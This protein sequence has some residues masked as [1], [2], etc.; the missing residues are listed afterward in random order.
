MSSQG[1][2]APSDPTWILGALRQHER[3]LLRYSASLVGEARARDVVQDAFLRLCAQPSEAVE[4]HVAAWLFT[5]CRNRALEL[6]RAERRFAP[7]EDDDMTESPDSGPAAKLERAEN[8]T[9]I[10]AAMAALSERHR[11]ALLLKIEGGLSYKEI[12]EVMDLS[13]GNVGFI[14]HSA[15]AQLRDRVAETDLRR[16]HEGSTP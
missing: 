12:A 5:V 15:I 11:E 8:H 2:R 16:G 9:R 7:M 13:V 4:G 1:T 3:S 10:G 6:R 14:L